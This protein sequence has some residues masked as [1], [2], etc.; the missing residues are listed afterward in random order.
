MPIELPSQVDKIHRELVELDH[1]F[2][3]GRNRYPGIIQITG[4][5]IKPDPEDD[6]YVNF[7]KITYVNHGNIEIRPPRISNLEE[8]KCACVTGIMALGSYKDAEWE[9][10]TETW[11]D[12]LSDNELHLQARLQ[13]YEAVRLPVACPMCRPYEN[14]IGPDYL[15]PRDKFTRLT[16]LNDH[17]NLS[18][19]AINDI[20]TRVKGTLAYDHLTLDPSFDSI[21]THGQLEELLEAPDFTPEL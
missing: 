7:S 12:N 15:G 1:A 16:H 5:L 18:F 17:H 3:R 19:L 2:W 14:E 4:K 13:S 21:F 11:A 8:I 6:F 20:I 10:L 9:E